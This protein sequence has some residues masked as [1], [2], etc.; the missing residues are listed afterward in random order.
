MNRVKL[1]NRLTREKREKNAISPIIATLLLI[2]IAIAAGVVVYAYVLGF[3]GN[4]T[5]NSGANISQLQ[6]ENFCASIT[7]HCTGSNEYSVVIQNTGNTAFPSGNFQIY[8]QD[9][10]ASGQ[11]TGVVSTC[12]TSSISPGSSTTCSGNSW[13]GILSPAPNAGDTI[14]VKVVAPDGGQ[15]SRG[16]TVIS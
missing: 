9:I 7:T 6:I 8:F 5:G 3:V 14:T 10:T 13:S 16:T 1:F 4:N 12:S 2:L 11:P 15:A